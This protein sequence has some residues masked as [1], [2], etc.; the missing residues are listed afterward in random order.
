VGTL[1]SFTEE[2]LVHN[3]LKAEVLKLPDSYEIS[4]SVVTEQ[5]LVAAKFGKTAATFKFSKAFVEDAMGSPFKLDFKKKEYELGKQ[6]NKDTSPAGIFCRT[7]W[8][9]PIDDV[10]I[11]DL[12]K[13]GSLSKAMF[14]S[15]CVRC[16]L[17]IPRGVM[18]VHDNASAWHPS[19]WADERDAPVARVIS[20][21]LRTADE[22]RWRR[23]AKG[24]CSQG[25]WVGVDATDPTNPKLH[26]WRCTCPSAPWNLT[27]RMRQN[28]QQ[29]LQKKG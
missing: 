20:A 25:N 15:K 1:T 14:G 26:K 29:K 10:V 11:K 3:F 5:W 17:N 4:Y 12:L 6:L 21:A 9:L 19:C 23:K 22:L 2:N 7:A 27:K 8:H 16:A 13:G 18:I 24:K 28:L